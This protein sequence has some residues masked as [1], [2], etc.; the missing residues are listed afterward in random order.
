MTLN[1]VTGGL[2]PSV[3]DGTLNAN[4]YVFIINRDGMLFGPSG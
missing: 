1:R 2:G 4:G 3:I